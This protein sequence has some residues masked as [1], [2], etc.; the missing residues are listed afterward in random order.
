MTVQWIYRIALGL[1]I[2]GLLY[3][4]IPNSEPNPRPLFWQL[5][6]E[7]NE[8][9][10]LGLQLK[11][12]QLIDVNQVLNMHPNLALFTKRQHKGEP[13]ADMYLEAYYDDV[14]D[15]GDRIIIGLNA[16][17]A[18]L[19]HIKKQAYQ[20]ELF[21]NNVIRIGVKDE[22]RQEIQLLTIRNI[23][24]IA[25]ERINFE[26][27]EKTF[28]KPEKFMHDGEGNAHLL[29]PKLGLDFIQPSEGLQILQFVSP[30]QFENKLLKP[31]QKNTQVPHD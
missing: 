9:S 1:L 5:H 8:L 14:F 24:V 13:E 26:V 28:S 20:P 12:D 25:G 4:F 3:W 22:F 30:D 29:Y 2:A 21:P 19:N 7:K 10:I 6:V 16:D 17:L 23:T 15:E 27:F 11:K 31:L 18:L